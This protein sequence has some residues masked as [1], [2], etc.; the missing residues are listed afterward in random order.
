M[1]KIILLVLGILLISL[2]SAAESA[3]IKISIKS[4]VTVSSVPYSG[5]PVY[6]DV[7][8]NMNI[9]GRTFQRTNLGISDIN[10]DNS[11]Q[12]D[13]SYFIVVKGI[14]RQGTA[15]VGYVPVLNPEEDI[16]NKTKDIVFVAPSKNVIKIEIYYNNTLKDSFILPNRLCNSNTK[17]ESGED[18][19]SCPSDCPASGLD[20]ACVIGKTGNCDF[21]CSTLDFR[22]SAQDLCGNSI[23][24]PGVQGID[25]GSACNKVCSFTEADLDKLLKQHSL[26]KMYSI[27]ASDNLLNLNSILAQDFG[28]TIFAK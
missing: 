20:G 15:F 26:K 12:R 18:R 17:C 19:L 27:G 11:F 14:G 10:L 2:A 6:Y 13:L 16:K 3:N 28:F 24:D 7:P 25:C 8:L 5:Y 23:Q 4:D 22:C 21:D 1:K 9:Q